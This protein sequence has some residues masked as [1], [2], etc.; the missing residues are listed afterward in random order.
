MI[1]NGVDSTSVEGVSD[2][3][4]LASVPNY[5]IELHSPRLPVPVLWWRSVGNTH[6]AFVMETMIDEL[7]YTAG[8]DPV[9]YRRGIL[10]SKRHLA[11]LDL[12]ADKSGWNNPLPAG[13]YRGIAVHESFG[14]IVA[15]AAEISVDEGRLKVHR[16]VCAI[17]CGLAVNPEGVRAQ[18]EG[19]IVF[20]LTALL[21]GDIT[22][23]N[24]RVKQRNFHDYK[25]ARMNEAP[26]TEVYIADS[27][28]KMGGAGEPG[29]PPL[30][31]AVANAIFAATGKRVR[32]LPLQPSDLV[33]A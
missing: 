1:R 21:Y 27:T 30:A 4:Y 10:K 24:G 26:L 18:M 17:D 2:S 14:S 25:I 16:V 23:E 8:K 3:P 9:A 22:L 12:V 20:G 19:C 33:K 28:E 15:Q 7:A 6:T 13:R 5:N 11:V 31:P 32:R 29:V